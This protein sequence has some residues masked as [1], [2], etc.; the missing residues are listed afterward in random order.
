MI[1]GS[2]VI[3]IRRPTPAD[4]DAVAPM[5]EATGMFRPQEVAIA[6][7]V[8]GDAV[9]RPGVDYHAVGA[10]D[11]EGALLGFA[12]FGPTPGT[13]HTWDIY[14]IVVDPAAQ[15]H[16]IGTRLLQAC[17]AAAAADGGRI[18]AIETSS[19]TDYGET[20]GFYVARGY[21][22][23]ARIANYYAPNDDLIVYTRDLAKDFAP[24]TDGTDHG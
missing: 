13:V 2:L 22:R 4:L 11:D 5:V 20:R 1:T 10:F 9:R 3:T 24:S 17:E 18:I 16:G 23:A 7:E 6:V 15:R 12:C 8:F 14:W 19:R 21:R